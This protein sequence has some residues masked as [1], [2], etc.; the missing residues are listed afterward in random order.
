M[1]QVKNIVHVLR[2]NMV[3]YEAQNYYVKDRL[4]EGYMMSEEF[5]WQ[6]VHR[7]VNLEDG[8]RVP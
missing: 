4:W 7:F 3:L 2:L 1:P 6:L 8:S 5:R